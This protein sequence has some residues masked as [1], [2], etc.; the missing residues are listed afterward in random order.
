MSLRTA[1][2][3]GCWQRSALRAL[4]M[5]VNSDDDDD[6]DDQRDDRQTKWTCNVQFRP[7]MRKDFRHAVLHDRV[8]VDDAVKQ[9]LIV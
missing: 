1:H 3:G 6:D 9:V 5:Q 4:V 7:D 8:G 2:S